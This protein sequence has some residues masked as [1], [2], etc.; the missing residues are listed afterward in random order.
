[1]HFTKANIGEN[2]TT[3][4]T[5]AGGGAG[6]IVP[7]GYAFHPIYLYGASNA[8]LNAGTGIFKVTANATVLSNGP[9]ATLADT[10]QATYGTQRVGVEPIA[11]AKIIGV[12]IVADANFAPNTAD[13][14][15]V[16]LGILLPA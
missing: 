14:D 2:A 6:M 11:A 12:S 1:L 9:T 16:L 4:L 15:A 5:L 3:A 10:V 13:V 8:D 7:T